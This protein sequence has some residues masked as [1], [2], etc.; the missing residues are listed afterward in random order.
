MTNDNELVRL[1]VHGTL[2][3]FGYDHEKVKPAVAQAMRRKEKVLRAFIGPKFKLLR[4]TR[5]K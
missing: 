2:H 3:L 4:D 1:L 5:T